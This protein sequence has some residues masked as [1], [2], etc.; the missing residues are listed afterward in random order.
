MKDVLLK[1]SGQLLPSGRLHEQADAPLAIGVVKVHQ[2][3]PFDADDLLAAITADQEGLK[4]W[5][6]TGDL[7]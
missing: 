7:Q 1:G 3:S 4:L 5:A 2:L 6:V